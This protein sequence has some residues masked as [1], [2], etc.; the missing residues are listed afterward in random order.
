MVDTHAHLGICEPTKDELIEG[1]RRVGVGRIL[2]VGMDE[3]SNR[4]AI[5]TAEAHEEVFA[6][7]GRHPNGAGGFDAA[8]ATDIEQLAGH[9]RVVAIGETGLDYYRDRTPRDEQRAAF[10]A[11][12]EIARRAGLAL[13]IHMRD[14]R[15]DD[16]ALT[17]TFGALASEA[18]GVTVVLHCC[19]VPPD[20]IGEATDRGW[21]CS[22]AGNVTYPKAEELREAAR[23]VPDELLLVE[24]DSPFLAPQAVRGEPNQPANVVDVAAA[25]ADERDVRYDELE[26]TV[27]ANAA[28]VFH[29]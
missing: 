3:A 16:A 29:W 11:Q 20:R 1:A 14:R 27:E 15:G 4:E 2:T 23:L 18:E 7:V 26:R 28:R 8:A 25:L 13:V 10:D 24:T 6:S 21:Y 12:I 22:F 5:A 19:S 17:D 9:E